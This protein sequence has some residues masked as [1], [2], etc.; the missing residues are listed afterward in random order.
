MLSF[1]PKIS[2]S[3]SS[4]SMQQPSLSLPSSVVSQHTVALDIEEQKDPM[5]N[6]DAPNNM[7]SMKKSDRLRHPK[8]TSKIHKGKSR[9]IKKSWCSNF[10]RLENSIKKDVIF[11]YSC[12]LFCQKKFNYGRESLIARGISNWKKTLEKFR[13]HE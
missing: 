8:F 4:N 9:S 13:K 10:Q 7:K 3:E 11:C 5:L 1:S 2:P 6:Q 12:Q